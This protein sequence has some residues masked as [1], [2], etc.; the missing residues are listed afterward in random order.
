[1][2][3]RATS[4]KKPRFKLWQISDAHIHIFELKSIHNGDIIMAPQINAY[5]LANCPSPFHFHTHTHILHLARTRETQNVTIQQR[6]MVQ[7][8]RLRF[9]SSPLCMIL[10]KGTHSLTT[11]KNKKGKKKP[12]KKEE[13][14]NNNN[15]IAE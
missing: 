14:A 12:Q 13:G 9:F 4:K 5:C 15:G 1:M 11:H 7:C 3:S 2:R 8:F 10:C 6:H